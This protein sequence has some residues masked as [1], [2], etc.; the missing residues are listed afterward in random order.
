MI[1]SLVAAVGDAWQLGRDNKMLWHLKEDLQNFKRL[2]MGHHLL[3]GHNTFLSLGRPLPGRPHLVLSRSPRVL[4]AGCQQVADWQAALKL[5]QEAGET[6]LMVVG[7]GEVYRQ[8]L[9][10]ADKIYLSRVAFTGA[11]DVYFPAIDA[12]QWHLQSEDQHPATTASL[13]WRYQIWQRRRTTE[14]CD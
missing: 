13:A 12:E 10:H 3:M 11:A 4:P 5:A 8:A 7:G 1:I 14:I 2:T 9:P 6:E